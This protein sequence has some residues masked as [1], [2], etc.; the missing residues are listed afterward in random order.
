MKFRA[1]A[2]TIRPPMLSQNEQKEAAAF[3]R[4]AEQRERDS[5]R[6]SA[7]TFSRY[8]SAV[9]GRPI[10]HGYPDRAFLYIG[11]HLVRGDDPAKPLKG[12][13]VFDLGAGDGIWS[14][15][16]AEQGAVVTSLEISPRQ[17]E[18][19]RERMRLHNLTWDARV[20][21]AYRLRDEFPPASFDLIFAEAILHH[22]TCDL[23]RVYHGM[24]YLLREGGRATMTEPYCASPSLR[25]LRERL[26]WMVPL[27][28][29]SPDERP[30]NDADLSPLRILFP[31]VTIDRYDLLARFARRIFRSA[32][33]ER[34]LF[35]FD[36]AV[37]SRST[38]RHLAGGVFIAARK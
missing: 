14:V 13:R 7:G 1:L 23:E 2:E 28:R 26:S 25:R 9:L 21:S 20:G 19:A 29:E 24:H 16:L 3:D 12:V 8:R 35:R 18:L 5:L 27:D 38:F 33:M 37:L 36:Q 11:R 17:V 34:T 10:H 22:L 4:L 32:R 30:L 31:D 15:I 6:T